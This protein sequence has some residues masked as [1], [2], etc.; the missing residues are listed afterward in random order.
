[1]ATTTFRIQS[2]PPIKAPAALFRLYKTQLSPS[3]PPLLLVPLHQPPQTPTNTHRGAMSSTSNTFHIPF[4]RAFLSLNTP[5]QRG[6]PQSGSALAM[7]VPSSPEQL[8]HGFLSNRP[9]GRHQSVSS[10]SS[11]GSDAHSPP[12]APAKDARSPSI[13]EAVFTPLA[14][15]TKHAGPPSSAREMSDDADKSGF[16]SNR[17]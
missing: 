6:G 3:P 13:S 2:Y 12:A 8:P 16:L 7:G 10:V 1:L 17:H 15:N 14:L 4:P 9:V 11:M 5:V